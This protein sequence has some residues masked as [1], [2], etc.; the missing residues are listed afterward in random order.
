MSLSRRDLVAGAAGL[1]IMPVA[2]ASAQAGEPIRVGLLT[3]KTGPF[4]SGGLD[5]EY[6]LT[7]FLDERK[8]ML[9]GRKVELT[10]ADTAGVPA[11]ARSAGSIAKPVLPSLVQRHA[12]S[13]PALREITSTWSATMN[14]E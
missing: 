9:A 14:T 2:R 5:M 10:V 4:A 8:S 12:C 3:T 7:M 6:A 13:S 11:T 1:C